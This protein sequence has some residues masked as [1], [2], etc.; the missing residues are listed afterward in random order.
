VALAHELYRDFFAPVQASWQGAEN[1]LVVADGPLG[2][3]PMGV[4]VTERVAAPSDQG[5][6]FEGYKNVPWLA[7]DHAITVLPSVASLIALRAL[8]PGRPSRRPFVGFGD[9][10]FQLASAEP[11]PTTPNAVGSA[12]GKVATRGF[13]VNLRSVARMRGVSSAQLAMLPPLPDTAEEINSIA[14]ALNADPARDVFLGRAASER[15]VKAT[16]LADYRVV[17]FATHG[18]MPGDLDGLAQPALALS[19]PE[20][21]DGGDGLLTMEEILSLRLDAD[22]VILSAC[23][24]GTAQGAGAEAVSG[25][26]RA[27]FYAGTRALLVSNW[28]VETTSAKVLTTDIFQRQALQPTLSRALALRE[29]IIS[30]MDGPGY[31]DAGSNTAIFSYAHPIFWAPFS[32]IGDGGA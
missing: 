4:L 21:A 6:L 12:N 14:R 9:P 28:P 18:L 25:L 13:P 5:L 19:A 24:T 15:Q 23:N 10:V 29:S 2:Q 7:R 8:P 26:G 16:N 17:A 30:L 20:A 3:L 11:A 22:W 31:V 32:L 1:L 27:F